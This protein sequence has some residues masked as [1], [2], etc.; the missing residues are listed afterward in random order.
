MTAAPPTV[1][2]DLLLL[3]TLNEVRALDLPDLRLRWRSTDASGWVQTS[4]AISA[5]GMAYA[6][7]GFE[8]NH[9]HT[10]V[11]MLDM[12]SG[13]LVTLVRPEDLTFPAELADE[14]EDDEDWEEEQ[15]AYFAQAHALLAEGRVWVPACREDDEWTAQVVGLDP[16]GPESKS[17]AIC[18][19]SIVTTRWTPGWRCWTGRCS[20]WRFSGCPARRGQCPVACCDIASGRA[21]W[22]RP[23]GSCAGSPVVAGGVVYVASRTGTVSAFDAATVLY[24]RTSAGLVALR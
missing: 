7:L 24:V 5:D 10:G 21:R 12:G 20:W 14:E 23:F 8:A 19:T 15:V 9:T 1:F 17:G 2:G 18:P 3:N 11:A 4:P 16:R 22:V 13:E 6:S